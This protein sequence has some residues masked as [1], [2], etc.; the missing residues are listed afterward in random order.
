MKKGLLF[1]LGMLMMVSTAEASDRVKT[2]SIL[3]YYN[4]RNTK[5]IQFVERG[6]K[7]YVF[8]NGE[9]NF[10][11]HLRNRYTSRN[12][13]RNNRYYRGKSR[14][15]RVQISRDYFGR[16]KRVGNVFIN[17]NRYGKVTRIGSV[18][19]DYSHRRMVR[20]GGLRIRYNRYGEVNYFGHVK[21]RYSYRNFNYDYLYNGIVL[22]YNDDYFDESNFYNNFDYYDQDAN[23]YYYKAKKGKSNK[24]PK[25]IKRKKEPKNRY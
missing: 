25:I 15:H 21:P 11:T 4:Y 24:N 10:N 23:F 12:I 22:D 9:L 7:F 20:V 8:P 19:I 3:D 17:Y 14:L 18:F 13:Y 2:S 6:I 16:V 5:P 1:I